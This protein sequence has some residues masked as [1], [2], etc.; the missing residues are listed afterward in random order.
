MEYIGYLSLTTGTLKGEELI[1]L[2]VN[3]DID[4][5]LSSNDS[6][7][8]RTVTYEE[9]TKLL[10]PIYELEGNKQ[11]EA[12]KEMISKLARLRNVTDRPIEKTT[13]GRSASKASNDEEDTFKSDDFHKESDDELSNETNYKQSGHLDDDDDIIESDTTSDEILDEDSII[14]IED[15]NPINEEQRA[16]SLSTYEQLAYKRLTDSIKG[17]TEFG[18]Y[19]VFTHSGYHQLANRAIYKKIHTLLSERNNNESIK[20]VNIYRSDK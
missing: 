8:S 15:I 11:K 1:T 3:S 20:N 7:I 13:K 2:V 19:D 16:V 10:T 14:N 5:Y 9:I 17:E 6:T 18:A 4:A 12:Y